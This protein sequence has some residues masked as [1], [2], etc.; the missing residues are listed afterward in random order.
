MNKAKSVVLPYMEVKVCTQWGYGYANYVPVWAVCCKDS[1]KLC[2]GH[3]MS[4]QQKKKNPYPH[5]FGWKLVLTQCELR[6]TFTVSFS[7]ICCMASELEPDEIL[8]F[9]KILAYLLLLNQS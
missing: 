3:S 5:R 2:M 1:A 9:W 4:N 6:H 8:I 7:I